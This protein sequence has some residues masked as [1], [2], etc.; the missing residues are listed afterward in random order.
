M[1]TSWKVL[2]CIA[3]AASIFVLGCGSDAPLK[4][5]LKSD[6][7]QG[8]EV[9][10]RIVREFKKQGGKESA[11]SAPA[12]MVETGLRRKDWRYVGN[13]KKSAEWNAGARAGQDEELGP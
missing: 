13:P 10:R 5:E 8:V 2:T 3:V 7:E 1:M 6:Y 11:M 12:G 9:G 4:S